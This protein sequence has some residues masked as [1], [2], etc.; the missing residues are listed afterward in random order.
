VQPR[1]FALLLFTCLTL[2]NTACATIMN[3]RTQEVELSTSPPQA[4]VF[5][6]GQELPEL[7]PTR[8]EL[9]RRR[10]H[11]VRV[12][13]EGYES[14]TALIESRFSLWILGNLPIPGGGLLILFDAAWGNGYKLVPEATEIELDLIHAGTRGHTSDE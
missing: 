14:T 12:E 6:D 4:R 5:I 8:T 2:L 11:F 7:T 9:T 13:K 10:A 1:P 3:S